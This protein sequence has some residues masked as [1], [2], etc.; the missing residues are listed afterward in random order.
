V[1]RLTITERGSGPPSCSLHTSDSPQHR[2][3]SPRTNTASGPSGPW[4]PVSQS[5][6][7][8]SAWTITATSCA[9]K[10]G[11]RRALLGVP[12]RLLILGGAAGFRP[13]PFEDTA[14][15]TIVWVRQYNPAFSTPH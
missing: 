11:A 4:G 2:S 12:M 6:K 10:A 8:D 3:S 7:S 1:P 9:T 5:G 15:D 13:R 14:R